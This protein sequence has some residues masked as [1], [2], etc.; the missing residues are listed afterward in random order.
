[1]RDDERCSGEVLHHRS[2]FELPLDA[3]ANVESP[4]RRT[5]RFADRIM[6]PRRA[7]ESFVG[8]SSPELRVAT[9]QATRLRRL[10]QAAKKLRDI[11]HGFC[12]SFFLRHMT[13]IDD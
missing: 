1:R 2:L 11:A 5:S 7:K 10:A 6:A 9:F 3:R 13:A 12:R 8:F 4:G